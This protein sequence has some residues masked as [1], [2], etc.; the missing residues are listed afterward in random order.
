MLGEAEGRAGKES[1]GCVV[2]I[3][4][5]LQESACQLSVPAGF[6]HSTWWSIV[7]EWKVRSPLRGNQE[8]GFLL[9]DRLDL[10]VQYIMA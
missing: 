4:D 8:T 1:V 7:S 3:Y 9:E 2:W 6:T 5:T 10:G